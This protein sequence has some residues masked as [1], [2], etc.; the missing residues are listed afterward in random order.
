MSIEIRAEDLTRVARAAVAF[1]NEQIPG[2]GAVVVS[3]AAGILTLAATD[4]ERWAS[5]RAVGAGDSLDPVAVPGRA[6]VRSLG[7]FRRGD[8]VRVERDDGGRLVLSSGRVSRAISPN[9]LT[10]EDR[11]LEPEPKV[12]VEVEAPV[13]AAREILDAVEYACTE[14]EARFYL[15]QILV[16]RVGGHLRAVATDGH[17][18]SMATRPW[19]AGEVGSVLVDGVAWRVVRDLIGTGEGTTRLRWLRE[20]QADGGRV[21]YAEVRAPGARVLTR[22]QATPTQFP[23]YAQVV[24]SL[25][26]DAPLAEATWPGSEGAAAARRI[27]K[28]SEE[29]LTGARIYLEPG[30]AV[31]IAYDDAGGSLDQELPGS[32]V[33]SG[34]ARTAVSPDYLI[35]ASVVAGD[36]ATLRLYSDSRGDAIIPEWTSAVG[37]VERL[38][39]LYPMRIKWPEGE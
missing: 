4:L 21:E 33:S 27:K 8:R 22:I 15:R 2:L 28:V 1:T 34:P 10:V 20:V 17:R 7:L 39:V 5:L 24:P 32:E 31:R 18:M 30:G 16:E 23:P 29:S 14:D 36:G 12:A 19:S 37:D 25:C 9:A 26:G 13:Q 3:G 35:D 38:Q 6:L 11:P